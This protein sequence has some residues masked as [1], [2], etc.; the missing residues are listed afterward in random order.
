MKKLIGILIG[1]AAICCV[2]YFGFSF[3]LSQMTNELVNSAW[4]H[5][6]VLPE[7]YEGMMTLYDYKQL[8]WLNKVNSN[9]VKAAQANL[10]YPSTQWRINS[11]TTTYAYTVKDSSTG[12]AMPNCDNVKCTIE[13]EYEDGKWIMKSFKEE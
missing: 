7:K 11:A 4:S 2:V 10:A 6:G 5:D 1:I 8:D 12:E 3:Y 13:W 9:R